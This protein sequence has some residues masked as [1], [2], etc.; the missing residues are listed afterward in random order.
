[1]RTSAR[2]CG[3][4]E[5]GSVMTSPER[6]PLRALLEASRGPKKLAAVAD[7]VRKGAVFVYPTETVYG[8]GGVTDL[9]EVMQRILVAKKRPS[10][11]PMILIA[12]DRSFF[13]KLPVVF[14]DSAE[15]LARAF[16]PGMLTLVLPAREIEEGIAIR[17]SDHPFIRALFRYIE[18]PLF[19]TSANLSGQAYVNDPEMIF[20]AFAGN[21]DFMVDA[22]P[23]PPSPPS[24]VVK[25]AMDNTVTVVR[26]GAVA[27]DAI[28]KVARSV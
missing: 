10:D 14:P 8:I 15:R 27:E 22:G 1:M 24:T 23:L 13:A 17:V 3:S 19:S 2:K 18:T 28:L 16:W 5:N 4:I 7:A 20:S 25:V 12:S 21:I 11:Q 26:H 6:I 9:P